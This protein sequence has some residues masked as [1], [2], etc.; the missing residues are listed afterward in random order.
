MEESL[1]PLPTSK[2]GPSGADSRV[3]GFV[4]ILGPCGSLQQT[5]LWG[6]VF[7]LTPQPPQFFSVR[8]FWG[9]ISLYWNPGLCGL[10]YSPVVSP[11]LSACKC[12]TTHSSSR[13]LAMSFL[14]P[15][16]PSLSLLLVWMN[17]PS[18]TPLVVRFSYSSIFWQ[19]WLCFVFKF[20]V[21]LLLVVWGGKVYLPM[22]PSCWKSKKFLWIV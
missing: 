16:C 18:L 10:S 1:P 4:Y 2:L 19:F 14:H 13:C 12:G 9:F 20:V 3:G 11:S 5:L 17:V 7:L 22:P 8:D 6:W 21:V 15:S